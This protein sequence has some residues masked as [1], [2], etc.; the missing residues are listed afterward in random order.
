MVSSHCP[1]GTGHHRS[2]ILPPHDGPRFTNRI[3]RGGRRS[4]RGYHIIKEIDDG[5]SQVEY[6]TVVRDALGDV[7]AFMNVEAVKGS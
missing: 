6:G 7:F 4:S 5:G 1:L 2:R 3:A